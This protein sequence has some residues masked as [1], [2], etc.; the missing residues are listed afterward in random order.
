LERPA[1]ATSGKVNGG[2]ESMPAAPRRKVTGFKK[3]SRAASTFSGSG[4]EAAKP[5]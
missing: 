2:S 1:K 3:S 5:D 4:G